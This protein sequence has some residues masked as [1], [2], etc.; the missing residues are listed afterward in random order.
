MSR[1]YNKILPFVIVSLGGEMVYILDQRLRSQDIAKDRAVKVLQDI[2]KSMLSPQFVEELFRPQP[3]YTLKSTKQIFERLAHSSIM[4]LNA[5]SMQKLFDLMLM[6]FKYQMQQ[7][8]Q[9]KELFYVALKHLTTMAEMV[10][11]TQALDYLNNTTDQ[12]KKL[13]KTYSTFDYIYTKQEIF[14]FFQEKHIKVS[15]FI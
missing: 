8:C 9:P 3:M 14:K 5:T 2:I 15:L 6:G 4:K 1:A 7:C 12:L 10:K 13:V 11:G